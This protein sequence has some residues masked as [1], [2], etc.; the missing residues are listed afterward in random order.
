MAFRFRARQ[1]ES[2]ISSSSRRRRLPGFATVITLAVVGVA[3]T[4]RHRRQAPQIVDTEN[5]VQLHLC[6]T[7]IPAPGSLI[8]KGCLSTPCNPNFSISRT[9]AST[10]TQPCF[11]YSSKPFGL[12]SIYVFLPAASAASSPGAIRRWPSPRHWWEG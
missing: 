10:S 7:A 4:R 3:L 12:A 8:K 6:F 11:L 2:S 1:R 9:I 5:L